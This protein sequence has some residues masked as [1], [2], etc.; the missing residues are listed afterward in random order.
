[1]PTIYEGDLPDAHKPP[2]TLYLIMCR[3]LWPV[4]AEVSEDHAIIQ[5]KTL[6]ASNPGRTQLIF[7]VERAVLTQVEVQTE[8]VREALVPKGSAVTE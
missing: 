8:V 2:D 5:A 4:Y 6:T 1:M 3:G 7:R